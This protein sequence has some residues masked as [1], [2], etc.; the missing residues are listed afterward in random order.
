M[1][2]EMIQVQYVNP[3]KPGKKK[4]TIKTIDPFVK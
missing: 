1:H 3:P 2:T 4:G